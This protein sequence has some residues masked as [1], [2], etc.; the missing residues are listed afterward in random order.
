MKTERKKATNISDEE[1]LHLHRTGQAGAFEALVRR[2]GDELF[3]FLYRFTGDRAMADDVFQETFLQVHLAADRFDTSKRFKPWLFTI[4]ANKARDAM[5]SRGRRKAAA[6]DAQIGSGEEDSTA[7]VDLLQAD[8]ELPAD[9]MENKE[10][11]LA[12]QEIV[13]QMPEHLKEVILLSYFQQMPYKDIAEVL[14]VP[15]GTVKSR[16]HAAVKHFAT[17]WDVARKRF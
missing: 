11:R 17:R 2:R 16:L 13:Q 6:L 10:L 12:V 15:L 5:R 8:T 9:L 14:D 7:F 3:R 4:A 1:L